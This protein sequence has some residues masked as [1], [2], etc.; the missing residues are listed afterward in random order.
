[1]GELL[2][3]VQA[4]QAVLGLLG[5]LVGVTGWLAARL[6]S[7]RRG[8]PEPRYRAWFLR[9][10]GSYR[11]PYLDARDELRLDRT[12]IP[13][14]ATAQHDTN[15]V[16]GDV[17]RVADG[18]GHVILLG[19]AGAGKS[20]A[21]QAY[22]VSLLLRRTRDVPFFVPVR[23]LAAPW[24][25]EPLGDYLVKL[26]HAADPE[27]SEREAR[28]TVGRLLAERRLVVLLDGLDE[29]D[30]AR[31]ERVLNDIH[32]FTRNDSGDFPTA[33]ARFV[34]TSRR[35]SFLRISRDWL[36]G[37]GPD[38]HREVALR[39]PADAPT[40]LYAVSP[41]T[42]TQIL[43]YLDRFR[44][45]FPDPDGPERFLA[46]L[47]RLRLV[48]L[49]RN[50]LVLSMSVGLFAERVQLDIPR[51]VAALYQTMIAEMLDRHSF[52]QNDRQVAANRFDKADKY[53]VLRGF[54]LTAL[55]RGWFGAFQ[56]D[57]LVR[58]TRIT[59]GRL[60]IAEDEVEDLAREIFDRSGL[61]T[62]TG[63]GRYGF[64]HRSIQEHL[65]AEQLILLGSA[66]RARLRRHALEQDWRQVFVYYTAMAD[67]APVTPFLAG[68]A[69]VAPVLACACLAGANCADR[70]GADIVARVEQVLEREPDRRIPALAALLSAMA[71]RRPAIRRTAR[72]AAFNWIT[73]ISEPGAINAIGGTY[74]PALEIAVT[75]IE[76]SNDLEAGDDL[77]SRVAELAPNDPRLVGPLWRQLS[78]SPRDARP[79]ST[80]RDSG[81]AAQPPPAPVARLVD[82]LLRLAMDPVCFA[83][84]QRQPPQ[85]P[86]FADDGLRREVYPFERGLSRDSNL[87]TLLC[88]AAEKEVTCSE[89]N[90]FLRARYEDPEA[91]RRLERDRGTAGGPHR[92]R[93]W[94]LHRDRNRDRDELVVGGF[95]TVVAVVAF[96]LIGTG[97][98]GPDNR[99]GPLGGALALLLAGAELGIALTMLGVRPGPAADSAGDEPSHWSEAYTSDDSRH[100]LEPQPAE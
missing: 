75:L 80:D 77:V 35:H 64:A 54:A 47:T 43:A 42:E 65:A 31:Y 14:L 56:Q 90:L 63:A 55:D 93:R 73:K 92:R 66:G 72:D 96:G 36:P 9:E 11:N 61:L 59:R 45:R 67:Q 84:L 7:V 69:G 33:R 76:E 85:R 100:W 17:E 40:Q 68:L 52:L 44:E 50:P 95:L 74:E 62:P 28:E 25:H 97:L 16:D 60:V 2:D 10:Y 12:Y 21:L 98:V 51:S 20:T 91:W 57:D 81:P 6:R 24:Q 82:R 8:A 29:V 48:E 37:G 5:A 1:M 3:Q 23:I 19:E 15:Q 89:P 86:P 88:W 41:L 30:P 18:Q 87:V 94:P 71:G 53:D 99:F 34:V 58:H 32:A 70:V 83:E 27:G 39:P 4:W 46:E 79:L 78:R 49:H 26:M 13:L 22:G 38:A